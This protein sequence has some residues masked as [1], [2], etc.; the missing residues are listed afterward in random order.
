MAQSMMNLKELSTYD[1]RNGRQAYV[2]VSGKIYN[3]SESRRWQEG[4]HEGAHQAGADLTE[5]LKAA[6][7]VRSVIERFPVVADLV[8]EDSP[9][10]GGSGKLI[11][12]AIVV[13]AIIAVIAFMVKS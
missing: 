6:P 8:D 13:A 9:A 7:H 1:G 5:E 3:V 2:A 12:G 4:A 11:I 10:E